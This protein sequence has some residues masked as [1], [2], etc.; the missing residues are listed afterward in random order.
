MGNNSE[1]INSEFVLLF[2]FTTPN[3][4]STKHIIDILIISYP[5]VFFLMLNNIIFCWILDVFNWVENVVDHG[6]F[7]GKSRILT[8]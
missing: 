8:N 7:V 5:L 2:E 1:N 3:H 4:F 6:V